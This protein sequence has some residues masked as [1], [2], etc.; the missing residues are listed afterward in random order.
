LGK[1]VETGMKG[2]RGKG[3]IKK[4]KKRNAQLKGAKGKTLE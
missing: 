1:T 4:A 3:H 2:K